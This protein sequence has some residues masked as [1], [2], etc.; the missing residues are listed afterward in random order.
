MFAH[1][2]GEG[3][4]HWDKPRTQNLPDQRGRAE[5]RCRFRSV[6]IVGPGIVAPSLDLFE[7]VPQGSKAIVTRDVLYAC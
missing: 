1:Q 2:H 4:R 6:V 3:D 7:V 5:Q